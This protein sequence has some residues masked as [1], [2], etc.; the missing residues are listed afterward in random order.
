MK[1]SDPLLDGSVIPSVVKTRRIIRMK[2]CIVIGCLSSTKKGRSNSAVSLHVFPKTHERIRLWLTQTNQYNTDELETMVQLVYDT[3][4]ATRYRM[5]SLH[6]H[7]DSYYTHGVSRY[8]TDT[9]IPTIFPSRIFRPGTS[10]S[11]TE[12]TSVSIEN[13]NYPSTSTNYPPY[14]FETRERIHVCHACGQNLNIKKVEVSTNT[15]KKILQDQS[16]E[17]VSANIQTTTII[18]TKNKSSDTKN[19]IK[20]SDK[21][22]WP[23]G[24]VS[25]DTSLSLFSTGQKSVQ[26]KIEVPRQSITEMDNTNPLNVAIL[27]TPKRISSYTQTD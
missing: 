21:Y 24:D 9:S 10:V 15:E 2:D 7:P 17:I 14:V 5:C 27:E 11:N 19:L 20:C 1:T 3:N 18:K 13:T 4:K 26:F 6:F 25:E 23:M 12:P 16:T 8:L 22:T